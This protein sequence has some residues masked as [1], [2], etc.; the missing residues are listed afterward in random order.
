MFEHF[1]IFHRIRLLPTSPLIFFGYSKCMADIKSLQRCCRSFSL[2]S[3]PGCA[4][5]SVSGFTSCEKVVGLNSG[6]LKRLTFTYSGAAG[7]FLWSLILQGM[8]HFRTHCYTNIYIYMV[9]FNNIFYYAVRYEDDEVVVA[10]TEKF[11]L[12]TN[13]STAALHIIFVKFTFDCPF[14]LNSIF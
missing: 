14:D 13:G 10:F 6:K 12:A 4:R 2:S 5:A 9:D 1:D 3:F 8:G 11:A 7:P